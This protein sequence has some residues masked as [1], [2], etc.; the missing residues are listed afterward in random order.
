MIGHNKDLP[1][2]PFLS[3]PLLTEPPTQPSTWTACAEPH[4]SSELWSPRRNTF[5]VDSMRRTT[6][7]FRSI[8]PRRRPSTWTACAEPHLCAKPD[9]SS[10]PAPNAT[11]S[12]WT[13]C[14]EPHLT[15]DPAPNAT[16]NVDSAEPH[17]IQRCPLAQ[18]GPQ[19]AVRTGAQTTVH[20]ASAVD[21]WISTKLANGADESSPY[22]HTMTARN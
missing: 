6:P 9:L 14:A 21:T 17:D 7:E 22:R 4:L 18:F 16:F 8:E 5:N 12:T 10:D 1:L 3:L 20:L 13:A 11:P 15:S 19:L 2:T